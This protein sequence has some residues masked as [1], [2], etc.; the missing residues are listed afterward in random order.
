MHK[1]LFLLLVPSILFAHGISGVDQQFLSNNPG[2]HF[3]PY[4]YL[5]AKHMVTGYDHLL[6]LAGV[7]FFLFRVRDVA[8]YVTLFAIGHSTTLLFGVLSGISVNIYLIDAIIGFS[9]VYKAFE[10]IGGFDKLSFRPNTKLAVFIFGLFHG[11]GLSSKLQ[12]IALSSDGIVYNMIG[13]NIG[14]EI[15]QFVALIFMLLFFNFWRNTTS[16][17]NHSQNGNYLLMMAGF[18]L[19]TYQLSGY[20]L[21]S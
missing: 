11:F 13:F 15:G 6:F 8:I 3:I 14:V 12:D 4:L 9:V 20:F 1:L 21:L 7:I 19:I 18:L 2:I 10:N 5:G 16:F 17:K